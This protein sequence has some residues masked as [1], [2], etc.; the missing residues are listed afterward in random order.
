MNFFVFIFPAFFPKNMNFPIG[1]GVPFRPQ[2]AMNPAS[3]QAQQVPS[4]IQ[5]PADEEQKF[6]QKYEETLAEIAQLEQVPH[7]FPQ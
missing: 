2:L 1:M 4:P 6:K 5:R 7:S 3:L